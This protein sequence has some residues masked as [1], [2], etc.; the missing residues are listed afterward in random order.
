MALVTIDETK[1]KRDG[2]CVSECPTAVIR[3]EGEGGYPQLIPGGD[4]VCLRC[5]H[6]VAV[7]PHGALNHADI[8]AEQCPP[9]LKDLS[10]SH[11]QAVQFLR[12]RRSVRQF[13][14]R[15]V[16][17]ETLQRLIEIARYAPTAGNAQLVQ[18]LV[19]RDADRIRELAEQV[20]DWMRQVLKKD[21]Q[22]AAAPYLPVLVAAWD[23]GIDAVLRSAPCLIVATAP[24]EAGNGLVDLTLAM[25]Y[26]E[27]AAPGLGVGTCWAGLLQGALLS[28]EPLRQTVG[29]PE[30]HSH[31]YPMMVGYSRATYYRLPERKP[32]V[33]HWK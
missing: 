11:E 15:P 26:L 17:K 12:S 6:C 19:I 3:I 20:I 2:L 16:D 33:I 30:G 27:L 24:K 1:C 10:V 23:M 32:P 5:G 29:I 13:K 4:P 18:W 7:C 8:P 22:P 31:H 9:I 25:S 28:H 14:D 21:P